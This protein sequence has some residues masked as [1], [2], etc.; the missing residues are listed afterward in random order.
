[1]KNSP[2][3]RNFMSKIFPLAAVLVALAGF[4]A[5]AQI[6]TTT[7]VTSSVNPSV[8]G[9]TVGLT[10]RISSGILTTTFSAGVGRSSGSAIYY[11]YDLINTTFRVAVISTD[12]KNQTT[13]AAFSS[14]VVAQGGGVGD[15]FVVFQAT[16]GAGGVLSSNVLQFDFSPTSIIATSA[17]GYSVHETATSSFGSSPGNTAVLFRPDPVLATSFSPPFAITGTVTFRNGGT[18]ITGCNLLPLVSASAQCSAVFATAGLLS[19]S[20][21]Y[22][23]DIKFAASTGT[24]TGGQSVALDI[25]PPV[26]PSAKVGV[27]Y[28]TSLTG[29]G[30]NGATTFSLVSGTFPTEFA[31]SSSGVITGTTMTAGPY[32]FTV[33]AVDANAVSGNRKLSLTVDKGDQVVTF[34]PPTSATVGT[35]IPLNGTTNSGLPPTYSV[36]TPAVCVST[37]ALLRLTTTGTCSITPVQSGDQNWFA[38]PSLPRVI[39]VLAPGGVQPLRLRTSNGISQSGTLVANQLVL[40]PALDPGAAFRIL[41][42][43]D[44]DGNKTL[45]LTF[46]NTTQGDTGEVLVWQDYNQASQRI[47]RTVRLL[48]RVDA[49]G[50]LDGDGFGDFVWRFTGQTPNFDDTGVSYIWF[51]NGVGV[52]Q[53]R[54][55]GGAPLSWQLIGAVDLNG[56]AAADMLYISPNNE[57]RALMATAGRSCANLSAG[58]IPPGF[59]ALKAAS[60]SRY[61]RGELLVRNA[62]TGE[63]RLISLDATGLALPPSTSDPNDPNASCTPSNLTV[64]SSISTWLTTDPTWRFYGTA[65]FNGD[66]LADIIWIRQDAT[67]TI[68]RSNGDNQPATVIDNAGVA[69]NGYLPIQP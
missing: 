1:M 35:T 15:S 56:D 19:I 14:I 22:S 27:A 30:A 46:L 23:G 24:L 51:T 48:W 45:D 66:G 3:I 67:L 6:L 34:I 62:T 57:I 61:G 44:V 39:S 33:Q 40:T 12:F 16:A 11:R 69:P 25:G 37:G 26:L 8:A 59:T 63:V 42:A 10:G 29:I 18:T 4:S 58:T 47:L 20:V 55:R 54:K 32:E 60:F 38:A 50:D 64:L 7:A 36:N 28:T 41:G 43:V 2:F 13:P 9:Q 68:W 49:V 17:I 31:L 21:V 52:S 53:V 65:D 5:H